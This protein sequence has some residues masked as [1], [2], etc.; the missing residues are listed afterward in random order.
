MNERFLVVHPRDKTNKQNE[1][2]DGWYV[3]D[4]V[5]LNI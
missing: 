2:E 1:Q 3:S 4:Q 5:I